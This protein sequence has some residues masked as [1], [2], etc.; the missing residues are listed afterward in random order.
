VQCG[1]G[2]ACVLMLVEKIAGKK[3]GFCCWQATKK[4]FP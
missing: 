1:G 4:V 3:I 2:G